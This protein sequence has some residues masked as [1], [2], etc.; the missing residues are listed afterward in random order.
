MNMLF[1]YGF[2][3]GMG[4]GILAVLGV[5]NIR[6]EIIDTPRPPLQVAPRIQP[7]VH[8]SQEE[9]LLSQINHP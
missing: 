8:S 2:I 9:I 1:L 7:E 3:L 5:Q 4:V 6:Q